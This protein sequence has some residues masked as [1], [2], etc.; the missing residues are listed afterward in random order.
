MTNSYTIRGGRLGRERLRVLS[1]V[2]QTGTN[3]F[4]D[5]LGIRSGM[6]CLDVGCG[7]G[8]VTR[9][10]ARRVGSAGR[11]VGIDMDADQL[12]IVRAEA[13]AH[14]IG[15][16][17]LIAADATA[18]PKDI[19]K[20][21]VVYSRFLLCHLPTRTQVFEWMKS[22]LKDGG[23]LALE[24]CDFTGHFCYPPSAAFNRYVT[25]AGDVMRQR[26]GDPHFGLKLPELFMQNGLRI[27][28][29][30]I[31]HPADIDGDPKLLNALSMELFA[32]AIVSEG[33]AEQAEVRE[34]TDNLRAAVGDRHV[35]ASVT[36]RIQ[37]WGQK[38]A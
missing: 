24:D 36:R 4:L 2:L 20:F 38:L 12:K 25:L 17:T 3:T 6:V 28:G 35:Y 7:G 37:V 5:R 31:A 21:D 18:P 8:D 30:E 29:I 32:E 11:A 27:G 33:L 16:I 23:I 19:D 34:L 9:E 15:N 22:R 26:G 1:N 10:L 13:E 14:N